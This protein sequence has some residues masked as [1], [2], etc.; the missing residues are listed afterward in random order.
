MSAKE[1]FEEIGY[2]VKEDGNQYLIYSRYCFDGYSGEFISFRKHQKK[3]GVFSMSASGNRGT[4]MATMEE[5]EAINMQC[6]EF[7]WLEESC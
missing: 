3:F 6:E 7:G 4:R 2:Q 1:K 5:L